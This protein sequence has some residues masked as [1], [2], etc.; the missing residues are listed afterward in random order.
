M[1]GEHKSDAEEVAA[2]CHIP[3]VAVRYADKLHRAHRSCNSK[4]SSTQPDQH[5]KIELRQGCPRLS[6]S[7]IW[8]GIAC[9]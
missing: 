6:W 8:T 4:L 1:R 9:W 2:E 5:I 3:T 7:G